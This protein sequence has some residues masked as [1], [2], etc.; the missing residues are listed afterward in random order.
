MPLPIAN[1]R[2]RRVHPVPLAYVVAAGFGVVSGFMLNE[3]GSRYPVETALVAILICGVATLCWA[4][5]RMLRDAARRVDELI[6]EELGRHES[7]SDRAA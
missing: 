3:F 7:R 6:D 5:A 2:P 4:G 1:R